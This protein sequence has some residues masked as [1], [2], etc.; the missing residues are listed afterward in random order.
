MTTPQEGTEGDLGGVVPVG[1]TEGQVTGV[2]IEDRIRRFTGAE[3]NIGNTGDRV[4]VSD[5]YSAEKVAFVVT[6]R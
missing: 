6:L 4:G 2:I 1:D 3:R 5:V